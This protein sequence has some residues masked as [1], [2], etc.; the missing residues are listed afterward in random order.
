MAA[1]GIG[2]QGGSYGIQRLC[3]DLPVPFLRGW[4]N[5]HR[6]G[7]GASARVAQHHQVSGTQDEHHNS[8]FNGLCPGP[9]QNTTH[10]FDLPPDG[11]A[12]QD[13]GVS[14]NLAIIGEMARESN[15]DRS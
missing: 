6:K 12:Q 5:H 11:R 8:G 9:D 7:Y 13:Q 1:T 3:M 14:C 4:H 15:S 2:R 10:H